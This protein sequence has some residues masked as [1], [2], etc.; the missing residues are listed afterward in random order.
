MT[1]NVSRSAGEYGLGWPIAQDND[2][3]TWRA[4]SNRLWPAK[5]L[6]DQHSRLVEGDVPRSLSLGRK[7]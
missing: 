2:Y 3:G 1:E 7:L 4:Y 6:V 5:Y